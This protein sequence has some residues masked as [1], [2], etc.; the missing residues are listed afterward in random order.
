MTTSSSFS[1]SSQIWSEAERGRWEDGQRG[2]GK[3]A[4]STEERRAVN[5]QA[6]TPPIL[7]N[8]KSTRPRKGSA[9]PTAATP[10]HPKTKREIRTVDPTATLGGKRAGDHHRPVAFRLSRDKIKPVQRHCRRRETRAGS[11]QQRRVASISHPRL[12]PHAYAHTHTHTHTHTYTYTQATQ[13]TV[14]LLERGGHLF[15]R[16][17]V[18]SVPTSVD[19]KHHCAPPTRSGYQKV[20]IDWSSIQN[21]K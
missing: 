9:F 5:A 13:P 6:G 11:G 21:K 4:V 16:L 12:G 3:S 18:V 20:K 14:S 7:T 19:T 2:G 15:G 1:V 10:P 17:A 8:T